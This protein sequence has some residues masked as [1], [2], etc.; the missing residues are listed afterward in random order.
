MSTEACSSLDLVLGSFVKLLHEF[1][2][3]SDILVGQ[4]LVGKF[5]T[6][7][8]F[9]HLRITALTVATEPDVSVFVPQFL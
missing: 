1:M 7:P 8:A 4:T 3:H 9:L 5:T 6:V 2:M